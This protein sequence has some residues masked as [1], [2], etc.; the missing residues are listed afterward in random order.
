MGERAALDHLDGTLSEADAKDLIMAYA[1]SRDR[2]GTTGVELEWLVHAAD[3]PDQLVPQ[4]ELEAVLGG[5]NGL[6]G[7]GALSFEPGGQLE[8]SSRAAGSLAEC[9]EDTAQ[10]LAVLRYATAGRGMVLLGSGLDRRATRLAVPEPRYV[11]LGRYYEQF[12]DAGRTLLC[13][14]ASVQVNLDAGDASDGWRGRSRRWALTN[15]LGPVLMAM[16]AN[17]PAV[18]DGIHVRSGRQML[19]FQTGP[20]RGALPPEGEPRSSWADYAL[21]TSVVSVQSPMTGRWDVPSPGF[22]LRSWLRGAGPW[23]VR[24]T[25][26]FHHLKSLVAPVRATGHLELRM[27]DAQPEDDWVVPLAVVAALLDE[28]GASDAADGL[29]RD[30]PVVAGHSDWVRAA[31]TGLSDPALAAAAQSVIRIAADGLT[32]LGTPSWVNTAIERY[33]DTYTLRGLSPADLHLPRTPEKAVA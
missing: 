26:V 18:L 29:V 16:F 8:L 2:P 30:W 15:A 3:A 12:G 27:I 1:F 7:G 33:A 6:P 13:G 24:T 21:D 14:T 4:L 20:A 5:I 32:R 28:E 19:R 31:T 22:T 11:A 10:D 25:D 17:S 9:A 23:P